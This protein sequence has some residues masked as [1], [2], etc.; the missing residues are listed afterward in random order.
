MNKLEKKSNQPQ[1]KSRYSFVKLNSMS[2]TD[3]KSVL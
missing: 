3:L 2:L 1:V